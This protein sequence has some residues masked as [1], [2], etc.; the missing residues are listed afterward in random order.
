MIFSF[1]QKA[2]MRPIQLH[3]REITLESPKALL[4]NDRNAVAGKGKNRD[5]KLDDITE[6][7]GL[8]I[9]LCQPLD[10]SQ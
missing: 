10:V 2:N 3:I 4:T 5:T 7:F 8:E 9:N 6:H 1:S